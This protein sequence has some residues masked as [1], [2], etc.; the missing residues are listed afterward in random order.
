MLEF[1]I[2]PLIEA[3]RASIVPIS[4]ASGNA[5]GGGG[6]KNMN[7]GACAR[8]GGGW[9]AAVRARWGES[10]DDAVVDDGD[11]DD[12]EDLMLSWSCSW[13]RSKGMRSD[14]MLR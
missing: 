12:G 4:V 9:T 1:L 11:D 6:G 2:E 8:S 13:T 3:P 5:Y 7:D 14:P 10:G